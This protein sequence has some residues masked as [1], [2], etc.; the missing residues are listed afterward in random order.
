MTLQGHMVGARSFKHC[1][2]LPV[3]LCFPELRFFPLQGETLLYISQSENAGTVY[4]PQTM[5]P[6]VPASGAGLQRLH[7]HRDGHL[8]GGSL[9]ASV[10]C[11]LTLSLLIAIVPPGAPWRRQERGGWL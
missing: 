8:E 11:S 5:F 2:S 6:Y 7:L 1:F 10:A 3:G 4:R 9:G